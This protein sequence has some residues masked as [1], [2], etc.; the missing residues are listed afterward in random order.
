MRINEIVYKER[1]LG[2]YFTVVCDLL[3]H[4]KIHSKHLFTKYYIKLDFKIY[5]F[6]TLCISTITS[7]FLVFP[8]N[9]VNIFHGFFFFQCDLVFLF[10]V[11][12]SFPSICALY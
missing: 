7:T 10:H 3:S 11:V 8:P 12:I 1:Y 5:R 2:F 6:S 4:L 9:V